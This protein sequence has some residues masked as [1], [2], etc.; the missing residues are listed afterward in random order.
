MLAP[1]IDQFVSRDALIEHVRA[2]GAANG[3][4]V[5]IA[6]SKLNKVY[7]GC[8]RGGN[9]RKR[10]DINGETSRYNT[11]SRLIGCPFSVCGTKG[12]DDQWTLLVCNPNHNHEASRDNSAHPSLRRLNEHAQGQVMKMSK[13]G[14]RPR[15]ILSSLRQSDPS[16]LAT[17]QDIYSV[18]KRIR[19]ENLRGRT[20]L[21]AL[22]EELKKVHLNT[23]INAILM[24]ILRTFFF[25]T[26]SPSS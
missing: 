1:P 10:S 11:S 9:Y 17:S 16:T 23:T 21:Q 22:V 14:V 7:I 18:C 26:T 25:L 19:L 12:K 15:E 8:D 2:F 13:A 4:G 6:R 3:Y 20:P 5:K 24:A